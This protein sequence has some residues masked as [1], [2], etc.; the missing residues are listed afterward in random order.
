MTVGSVLK[1][2][3]G[4]DPNRLIVAQVVA[5]DGTVWNCISE[6]NEVPNS[7]LLQLRI[8]HPDLKTLPNDVEI[9]RREKN[10]LL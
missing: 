9:K 4:M 10:R 5:E 2:L 3:E 6:I 1:Q 8:S 7:K